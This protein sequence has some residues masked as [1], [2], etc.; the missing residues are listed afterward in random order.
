MIIYNWTPYIKHAS[1][2]INLLENFMEIFSTTYLATKNN[3][4]R[5]NTAKLPTQGRMQS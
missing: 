5:N 4:L 2:K 3:K 1:P